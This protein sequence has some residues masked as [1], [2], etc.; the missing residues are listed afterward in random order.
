MVNTGK[1]IQH[2]YPNSLFFSRCRDQV[3]VR[4]YDFAQ[5]RDTS[6]DP[7]LCLALSLSGCKTHGLDHL[8]TLPQWAPTS[9]S[10]ASPATSSPIQPHSCLHSLCSPCLG[11]PSPLT[12]TLLTSLGQTMT[13]HPE[14][15]SL[16]FTENHTLLS[17]PCFIIAQGRL[18]SGQR[19]TCGPPASKSE[20]PR[21]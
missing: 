5:S 20:F 18:V 21:T 14:E 6:K 8:T 13:S 16:P 7:S 1:L 19:G 17:Y 10:A 15:P 9:L 3:S 2:N 4:L 11:H 12:F